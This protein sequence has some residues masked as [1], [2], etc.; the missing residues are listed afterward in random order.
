M[1]ADEPVE[2]IGHECSSCGRV[3]FPPDPYGC[4]NCGAPA[5]AL[6]RCE[7]EAAGTIRAL[8][9]VHRHHRPSPSTPF[10][11]AT[12]VLRSGVALK[13]I[14]LEGATDRA[15]PAVGAAVRGVPVV[16]DTADDG[17]D[18]VDLRFEVIENEHD[19][20]HDPDGPTGEES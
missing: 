5:D 6:L 17:V 20:D 14:V 10:T 8:A 13:A 12:I 3:A 1:T 9:V 15:E 19:A 4:E 16:V 11:V 7:L 18:V 2:L